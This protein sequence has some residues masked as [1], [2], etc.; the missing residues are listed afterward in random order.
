MLKFLTSRVAKIAEAVIVGL[1]VLWLTEKGVLGDDVPVWALLLTGLAFSGGAFVI[2]R[3]RAMA[4]NLYPYYAEH[5]RDVLDTLQKVGV[6]SIKGVTI[7]DFVERGILGPACHWLT[8][9]G[10]EHVRMTVIRPK[11]PERSEFE[12][13]WESGHSVEARTNFRLEMAGTLAG[14]AYTRGETLWTN[15]VEN[16]DRWT[17]HP[18]ARPSRKYGSLATVPVRKGEEV[19]AVLNVISTQKGAFS[20]ADLHYI[21]L[22]GSLVSLAYSISDAAGRSEGLT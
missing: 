17:K 9:L 2:G 8:Q 15:D 14:H 5:V 12:L 3:V 22:L 10:S 11:E 16:D 4:T 19:V 21:E 20:P 7:D 6:G 1:I 18:K 13:V